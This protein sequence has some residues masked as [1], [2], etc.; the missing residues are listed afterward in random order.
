MPELHGLEDLPP[1]NQV[2]VGFEDRVQLVLERHLLALKDPPTGLTEDT[3]PERAVPR[4]RTAERVDRPV[5]ERIEPPHTTR[6]RHD[7]AG[8][9]HDVRGD[10][11]ER[12]IRADLVTMSLR[13]RHAL[14]LLHPPPGRTR[15][16]REAPDARRKQGVELPDES[17]QDPHG[18]PQ[19]RAVR[20]MV[21]IRFD[22]GR[23]DPSFCPS[24]RPRATAARTIAALMASS[25]SGLS[26]LK[27]RLNASCLGT[28]WLLKWVK[29]RNV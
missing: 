13:G 7:R 22:H 19:Q 1:F 10:G 2:G 6:A 5:R 12:P 23:V 3:C 16:V 27:A 20:R 28:R 18:V 26:R 4:D 11:D 25:V 29:C 21:D 14:D 9:G 24:S 8:V 17:R 15:A